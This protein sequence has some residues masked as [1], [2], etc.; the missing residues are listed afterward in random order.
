MRRF[1][2]KPVGHRRQIGFWCIYCR[3]DAPVLERFL[4][5]YYRPAEGH[6]RIPNVC[7]ACTL[8]HRDRGRPVL[9]PETLKQFFMEDTT[10]G[11]YITAAAKFFRVKQDRILAVMEEIRV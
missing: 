7:I 4:P 9:T 11:S 1:Q 8:E 10:P 3:L 2:K 6:R 5:D